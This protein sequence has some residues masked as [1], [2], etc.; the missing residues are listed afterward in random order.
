MVLVVGLY[1]II[2]AVPQSFITYGAVQVSSLI[3]YPSHKSGLNSNIVGH[4]SMPKTIYFISN[5]AYPKFD[6]AKY[7]VNLKKTLKTS[8]LLSVFA[9][10]PSGCHT[11]GQQAIVNRNESFV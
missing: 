3:L 8:H 2:M 11:M 10:L 6:T 4:E 7:F 1:S 9:H 5:I